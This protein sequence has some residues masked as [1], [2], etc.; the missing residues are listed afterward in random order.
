MILASS[1]SHTR[2]GKLVIHDVVDGGIVVLKGEDSRSSGII[3]VDVRPDVYHRNVVPSTRPATSVPVASRVPR[4]RRDSLEH[5]RRGTITK[6][7][8]LSGPTGGRRTAGWSP[9]WRLD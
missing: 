2:R 5:D 7:A 9:R 3:R 4:A 6:H 1:D 8:A